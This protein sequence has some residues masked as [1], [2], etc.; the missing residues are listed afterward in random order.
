VAASCRA[1]HRPDASDGGLTKRPSIETRNGVLYINP[2]SAG[3]RRFRLP[4]TVARMRIS[5]LKIEPEIVE[6]EV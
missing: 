2:G 3:P 5:G 4:I 6:L 1:S